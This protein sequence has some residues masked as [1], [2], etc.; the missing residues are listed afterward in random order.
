MCA[1]TW[2]MTVP[3]PMMVPCAMEKFAFNCTSRIHVWRAWSKFNDSITRAIS[4]LQVPGQLMCMLKIL[5]LRRHEAYLIVK[6]ASFAVDSV[7]SGDVC[8]RKASWPLDCSDVLNRW[9]WLDAPVRDMGR[10]SGEML[11]RLYC[12]DVIR[13]TNTTCLFRNFKKKTTLMLYSVELS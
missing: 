13:N 2:F 6:W 7:V 9:C 8:G 5:Q 4:G 1:C 10:P 11:I 3:S 12:C